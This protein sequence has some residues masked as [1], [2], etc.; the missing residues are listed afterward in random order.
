VLDSP[1]WQLGRSELDNTHKGKGMKAVHEQFSVSLK[2]EPFASVQ[3]E[4]APCDSSSDPAR[5][6]LS[7]HALASMQNNRKEALTNDE[8]LA[9]FEKVKGGLDLEQALLDIKSEAG[10]VATADGGNRQRSSTMSA[11]TNRSVPLPEHYE[12]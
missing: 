5:H 9:L 11:R 4:D 1:S 8:Q 6:A 3:Q 2:F 10:M 7:G 12:I